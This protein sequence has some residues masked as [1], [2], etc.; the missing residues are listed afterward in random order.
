MKVFCGATAMIMSGGWLLAFGAGH[1]GSM[2]ALAVGVLGLGQL[3]EGTELREHRAWAEL[4]QA[5]E[6]RLRRRQQS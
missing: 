5:A 6:S 3:L 1:Q 4:L 2:L